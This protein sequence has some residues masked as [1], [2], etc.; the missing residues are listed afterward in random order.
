MGQ[1]ISLHTFRL[2]VWGAICRRGTPTGGVNLSMLVSVVLSYKSCLNYTG[3]V[4]R[5]K[6][7][8]KREDTKPGILNRVTIF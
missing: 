6:I 7:K 5:L 4:T 3:A 2:T 1:R 8:L